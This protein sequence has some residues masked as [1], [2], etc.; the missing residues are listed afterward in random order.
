VAG[1]SGIS[2][3]SKSMAEIAEVRMPSVQGLLVLAEAQTAIRSSS[4]RV[5]R[6][7]T[8]YDAQD[9]FAEMVTAK[10]ENWASLEKGWKLYEPLPQT[11]E[12]AVMWKEFVKEFEVWKADDEI[13]TQLTQ[14][15]AANR[16]EAVQ[17][18]LFVQYF[19]QLD[20][21]N[22]SF[23]KAEEWLN[24]IVDLNVKIGEEAVA[25]GKGDERFALQIMTV[26]SIAAVV[27]LAFLGMFVI[28]STLSQLGGEPAVVSEIVK[29]VAAGDLNVKIDT[30]A[31]DTTSMMVS[32]K[33]MVAKLSEVIR[34]TQSVVGSASHGDLSKR[35]DLNGKQGFALDLSNSVNQLAETSANIIGDMGAVLK[36]MADGDLTKRVDGKYQETSR[37]WPT[38]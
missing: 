6:W 33:L 16:S 24:K 29:A 15:L 35:L 12:E 34:E 1:W 3:V 25:D 13:L 11:D 32:V 30:K 5:M 14:K 28:R 31:G 21:A 19:D 37:D 18:E 38:R 26:V 36:V 8:I 27:I 23:V 10:K 2:G 7:E 4:R 9:K 20:K 22:V 17:K